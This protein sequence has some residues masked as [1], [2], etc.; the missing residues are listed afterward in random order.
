MKISKTDKQCFIR[1][2]GNCR[3]CFNDGG[4]NLQIKIKKNGVETIKKEVYK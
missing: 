4:C 2:Q 1:C 3:I